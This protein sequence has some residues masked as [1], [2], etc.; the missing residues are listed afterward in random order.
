MRCDNRLNRCGLMVLLGVLTAVVGWWAGSPLLAQGMGDERGRPVTEDGAPLGVPLDTP[1]TPSPP[2]G[3]SLQYQSVPVY[4]ET[5]GQPLAAYQVEVVGSMGRMGAVKVVGIGNGDAAAFAEPPI[6][7][8]G[9]AGVPL[10]D[11]TA[12]ERGSERIVLAAFSL[13]DADSLPSGIVKVATVEYQLIGEG[14]P[15]KDVRFAARLIAAGDAEGRPLKN[16]SVS[17]VDPTPEPSSS[18]APSPALAPTQENQ[19]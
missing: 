7:T 13:A 8:L 16:A 11:A 5:G 19:P 4:I 3:V 1:P 18:S 6:P 12:V 17:L 14:E 9:P 10:H 15:R 2:P